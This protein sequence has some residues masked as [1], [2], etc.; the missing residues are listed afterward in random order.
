MV[1]E[2]KRLK[3]VEREFVEYQRELNEKRELVV[4]NENS[5]EEMMQRDSMNQY[6]LNEDF[7]KRSLEPY[8]NEQMNERDSSS[9]SKLYEVLKRRK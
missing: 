3:N 9:Y 1:G 6:E 7:N 8:E 2:L 5:Q 4:P